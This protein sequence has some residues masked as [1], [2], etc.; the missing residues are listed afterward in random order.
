[1]CVAVCVVVLAAAGLAGGATTPAV[2]DPVG[3]IA[4]FPDPSIYYPGQ[5]SAGPDGNVWFTNYDGNSIGR[6]TPTGTVTAFTD[7]WDIN[8]PVDITPGPDGDLWFTK[9]ESPYSSDSIGRISAG[10]HTPAACGGSGPR[11]SV[12]DASVLEGDSGPSR[13]LRFAVTL[14][15]PSA[16][17][18]D[19]NYTVYA[20]TASYPSDLATAPGVT[21]TLKFTPALS[22]GLTP[23]TKFVTVPVVADTTAET[24]KTFTVV[25]SN[26]T[27]AYTVAKAVGTGTIIDD[28]TGSA[29]PRA[30]VAPASACEG[31]QAPAANKVAL[32]V[33][34]AEPAAVDG[35]VTVAVADGTATGA[36]P[37]GGVPPVGADY[38][39]VPKSG[40]S[41][42]YLNVAFK[43]GQVQKY[44]TLMTYADT[45]VEA[46]ETINVT[47]DSTTGGIPIDAAH[48]ATVATIV[49][50]DT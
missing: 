18:V 34:L 2:A 37:V 48:S 23:T 33:T 13:R 38:K 17:E 5:I 25:L 27:G 6:I 21:K 8:Q 28:D 30:G 43:A 46:G 31:N 7:F 14:N 19:V 10:V 32:A 47:I 44:V 41:T 15:E 42:Q 35:T 26:P 1:M 22:T 24:D 11:V 4:S 12:G 39:L 9:S 45:T 20:G 40:Q 50:D 29:G 49:N 16:F 3:T 36:R